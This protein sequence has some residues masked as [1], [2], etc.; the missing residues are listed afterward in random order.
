MLELQGEL[1]A[2]PVV[3]ILLNGVAARVCLCGL[4]LPS[5]LTAMDAGMELVCI[6][7]RG[8]AGIRCACYERGC[9]DN[10]YLSRLSP[11]QTEQFYLVQRYRPMNW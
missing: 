1:V 2:M 8:P 4:H 6:Q 3:S 11:W 7:Y 5:H 10:A 9:S